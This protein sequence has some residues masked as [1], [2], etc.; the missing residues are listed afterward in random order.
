MLVAAAAVVVLAA[1]AVTLG[2]A[3]SSGSSQAVVPARGS[4]TNALPGAA[5]VQKLLKGI[6]QHG[7]V[8]GSQSAPATLVEY[9]DL[10]CPYCQQF[11]TQAM[12]NLIASYVRTG[13]VKIEARPIAFIGTDSQRG[14][15]AAIAAGKQNKLFN[16]AQILYVNQGVENTGWLN[17]QM[18][19]SAAASI[20]GLDVT[21]LLADSTS[22]NVKGQASSYDQLATKDSVQA[23][24]TI[25][26]GKSGG[27]LQP[28]VLTSPT[29]SQSVASAINAALA[30]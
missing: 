25:L 4:L 16:F 2:V 17:E 30:G 7:N 18:V 23:T 9:V 14:R 5:D 20:P 21:R 22:N 11:E 12:P 19:A 15:L 3:L 29:D 1:I 10:Q 24:P 8:L 27:S 6:P 26:V 28:V 13:K